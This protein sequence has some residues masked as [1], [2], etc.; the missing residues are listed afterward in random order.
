MK[1]LTFDAATHT[2]RFCGRLVPGVS[3]VIEAGGGRVPSPYF[4]PEHAKRGANVHLAIGLDDEGTLDSA[5]LDPALAGY[6]DAWERFRSEKGFVPLLSE[7]ILYSDAW[8]Y[9]GT[10]DKIG[11]W[12]GSDAH[13]VVDIKS[14]V[15]DKWHRVQVSGYRR[16]AEDVLHLHPV[17]AVIVYLKR[18]GAYTVVKARLTD[19][20]V[21]M[22]CLTLYKWKGEK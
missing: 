21:F 12:A 3:E 2:Y 19:L 1:G 11:V 14:G 15:V 9:A 20:D 16:L 22:S 13:V 17:Q 5:A 8:D 18:T 4:K 6:V 10:V 7:Q